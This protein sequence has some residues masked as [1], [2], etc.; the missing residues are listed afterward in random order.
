MPKE[1]PQPFFRCGVFYLQH[2]KKEDFLLF[3]P[4]FRQKGNGM[5]IRL[6]F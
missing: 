2:C 6:M 5:I 1:A 3:L 4:L